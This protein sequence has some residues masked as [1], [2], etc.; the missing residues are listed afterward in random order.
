ML[1]AGVSCPQASSVGRL[2]DGICALICGKGSVSYEGEGASIVEGLSPQ[3]TPVWDAPESGGY[4]VSFYQDGDLRRFDTRPLIRAVAADLGAGVPSGEIARKFM[5]ALCR[6]AADQCA[7]LNPEH[8]PVVLSGGVFL[9][10]FL[11][12]GVTELLRGTGL[13][14]FAIKGF[15]PATR[16]LPGADGRCPGAKTRY[17]RVLPFR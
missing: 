14:F 6:M 13:R 12:S 4:P 16:D 10:R 15:R 11:L 5:A 2:F 1:R 7:A 9:N 8:L 3:E 17:L